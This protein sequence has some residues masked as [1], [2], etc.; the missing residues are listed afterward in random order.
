[1]G[2]IMPEF[3][4]KPIVIEAVQF[5][6]DDAGSTDGVAPSGLAEI[7]DNGKLRETFVFQFPGGVQEILSG[8]WIVTGIDGIRYVVPRDT[9]KKT[10]DPA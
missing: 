10:Y 8:D 5:D 2:R 7:G 4:K 6:L 3:R 9:F 1:M